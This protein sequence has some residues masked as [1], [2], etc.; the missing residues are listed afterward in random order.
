MQTAATQRFARL[1]LLLCTVL[2]VAALH[3]VGHAAVIDTDHH[4]AALALSAVPTIEESDG[5]DGDGCSHQILMPG[6]G[7]DSSQRWDV[8]LAALDT[9]STGALATALA[10]IAVFGWAIS[11]T[12][13]RRSGPP[14]GL[15]HMSLG[16]T[17]TRLAVIR[18]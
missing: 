11:A 12:M 8:C 9:L 14:T 13:R 1:L 17:L 18:T 2:G 5:C 3:T 4:A 16:L 15:R 7:R 6:T 10:L